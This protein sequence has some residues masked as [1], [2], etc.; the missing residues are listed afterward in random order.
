MCIQNK[1]ESNIINKKMSAAQQG[2]YY[3]WNQKNQNKM[4]TIEPH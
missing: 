4:F 2:R 1:K 3:E